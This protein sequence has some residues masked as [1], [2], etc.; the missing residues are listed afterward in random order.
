MSGDNQVDALVV[1]AGVVGLATAAALAKRGLWTIVLES[2]SDFGTGISSRNSEVIHAGIYYPTGSLKADLCV[3]G[4]RLLYEYAAKK[5]FEARRIG[6]L[7]V[8]SGQ[9]ETEAL[10][11][12][13]EKGLANGV[14][15]LSLISADDV[16][17]LEPDIRA[18]CAIHSQSTGVVDSH[19][20]MLALLGD[21]EEAGGMLARNAPFSRAAWDGERFTVETGGEEPSVLTCNILINAAGLFAPQVASKIDGLTGET[22]PQARFAKG[23]Y[24]A[25]V[26][27]QP[28]F[29]RLIYPMP[30]EAGLGIHA[31]VD[32]G[33]QVRF[34]P[35]VE[36]I[37]EIDY[38]PR[39]ERLASFER[40][41][42]SYYP[43][44]P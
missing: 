21:L 29:K 35:D 31:T 4:K 11:G 39:G 24:F 10:R 1:G 9:K 38:A 34:G 20:F 26:G 37:D 14:E 13:Y 33:G 28:R 5:G 44:L 41:I 27:K 16:A 17:E 8:A 23:N 7:I 32:L 3:R 18:D 36:W 2:E 22:I 30:N 40:A 19:S 25:P 6:K 43:A 12:L 15:E 42:Q